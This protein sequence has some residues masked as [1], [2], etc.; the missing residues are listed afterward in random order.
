MAEY[1]HTY[2]SVLESEDKF[3]DDLG[4]IVAAEGLDAEFANGFL[5]T[6]S[7]AFTNALVHGNG[8]DP[9]KLVTVCVRVSD[10]G[11][12]A[13]VTDEGRGGLTRIRRRRP[14][15]QLADHGRGIALMQHFAGTLDFEET[16]AGGLKVSLAFNRIRERIGR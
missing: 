9:T 10:N 11:V 5:L 14:A 12:V 4:L 16:A 6:V 1:K 2:P 15:G 8:L 13:Q 7:E 3:L